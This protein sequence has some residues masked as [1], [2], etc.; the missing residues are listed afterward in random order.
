MYLQQQIEE[1]SKSYMSP[2]EP[3]GFSTCGNHNH[4]IAPYAVDSSFLR[5]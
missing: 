2:I 4:G 5:V 3:P 1:I